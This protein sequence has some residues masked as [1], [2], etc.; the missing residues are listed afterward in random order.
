MS[1]MIGPDGRPP[2]FDGAAWISEDG[3]YWWNGFN[4]QLIQ[5]RRFRPP[6][7]VTLIV[8]AVLVIAGFVISKI[9]QPPPPPYGVTDAKI[10]S[11]TQFEFDY[12]RS[13][14]CRNLT[15]DYRFYDAGSREV[16]EFADEKQSNVQGDRTL[17][18]TIYTFS[19][20]AANAVRFDAAPTCHV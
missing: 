14:T 20:I 1:E 15:F 7:A 9:P 11:S 17:H 16:D 18:F 5:K 6:I 19:P 8:V 12:R 4:W 13:S 3:R 10:D 2:V